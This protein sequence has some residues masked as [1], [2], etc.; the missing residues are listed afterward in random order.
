MVVVCE[1]DVQGGNFLHLEDVNRKL[2]TVM[3]MF[4]EFSWSAEV[5]EHAVVMTIFTLS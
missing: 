1:G 3:L 2:L 4:V 5:V